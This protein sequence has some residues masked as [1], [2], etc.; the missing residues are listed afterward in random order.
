MNPGTKEIRHAPVELP[1]GGFLLNR[2]ALTPNISV[3]GHRPLTHSFVVDGY[4]LAQPLNQRKE[5]S[6]AKSRDLNRCVAPTTS[7][8]SNKGDS[9]TGFSN[10]SSLING[11]LRTLEADAQPQEAFITHAISKDDAMSSK[12]SAD[13]PPSPP[14]KRHTSLFSMVTRNR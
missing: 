8:H 3:A 9:F 2:S 5:S 12:R 1:E 11:A 14:L 6:L 7:G 13:D 10:M 4:A